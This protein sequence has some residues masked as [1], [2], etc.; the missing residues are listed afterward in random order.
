[1]GSG[2]SSLVRNVNGWMHAPSTLRAGYVLAWGMTFGFQVWQSFIGGIVAFKTLPRQTFGLLQSKTFP[3]YFLANTLLSASLLTLDMK[4]RPD[5]LTNFKKVPLAT[6]IAL[7]SRHFWG[8]TAGLGVMSLG[9]NVLNG[10]WVAPKTT[11]VMFERHRLERL[12]GR[13]SEKH[14]S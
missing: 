10:V 4:L 9:L 7:N 12:E 1:M 6:L 5:L 2:I 3:V 8:S 11:E 14:A 13:S